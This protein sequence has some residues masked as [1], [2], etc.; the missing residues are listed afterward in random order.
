M[1]YKL[2]YPNFK[3]FYLSFYKYLIILLLQLFI[4]SGYDFTYAQTTNNSASITYTMANFITSVDASVTPNNIYLEYDVQVSGDAIVTQ[5]DVQMNY[6]TT[7]FTNTASKI[8]VTFPPSGPFSSGFNT[9]IPAVNNGVLDVTISGSSVQ[10]ITGAS[11]V[12]FFHVKILAISSSTTPITDAVSFNE[13]N[14]CEGPTGV[15]ISADPESITSGSS[16]DLAVNITGGTSP[17]SVVYSNGTDQSTYNNFTNGDKISV[18]PTATTTYSIISVTDA[19]GITLN[20]GTSTNLGS[21]N[22]TVTPACDGPTTAT[23]SGGGTFCSNDPNDGVDLTV[24]VSGGSGQP[25]CSVKLKND[26]NT[27]TLEEGETSVIISEAPSET[28]TYTIESVTYGTCSISSLPGSAKV[29]P[30]TCS[31]FDCSS[32]PY[33]CNSTNT[34]CLTCEGAGFTCDE[35]YGCDYCGDCIEDAVE[36]TTPM[37]YTYTNP[38][39][40]VFCPTPNMQSVTAL[41]GGDLIA[42]QGQIISIKGSGFG[43]GRGALSSV[44]FTNA[45]GKGM[46]TG[47]GSPNWYADQDACDYQ[48]N[49]GTNSPE[50]WTD[51]EIKMFLPSMLLSPVFSIGSGPMYV[52]TAWNA[53]SNTDDITINQSYWTLPS[54]NVK[55]IFYLGNSSEYPNST[56]TFLNGIKFILGPNIL[57][58]QGAT[59]CVIAALESWACQLNTPIIID[60]KSA[61]NTNYDNFI[62]IGS[63]SSNFMGTQFK[64]TYALD[65]T[66][67]PQLYFTK[68]FTITIN[69]NISNLSATSSGWDYTL[70]GQ[71]FLTPDYGNFYSAILHEIGHSLLL[72][73]LNNQSYLMYW[74]EPSLIAG[75]RRK[76]LDNLAY[77]VNCPGDISNAQA[78]V[79][80]SEALTNPYLNSALLTTSTIP[81]CPILPLI[82]SFTGGQNNSQNPTQVQLTWS[83]PDPNAI[84]TITRNDGTN[85]PII[86]T[87]PGT[88]DD[89]NTNPGTNYVYT[90]TASDGGIV[91]SQ[92]TSVTTNIAV[93]Q[94]SGDV[95]LT[96]PSNPSATNYIVTRSTSSG[97]TY[98]TIVTTTSASYS[99]NTVTPGVTYY[100]KIGTNVGG[101]ITYGT[102]YS[103]TA[104][105][106]S[107]LTN[108]TITGNYLS[109]PFIDGTNLTSSGNVDIEST[110]NIDLV[111]TNS[112]K[113]SAGFSTSKNIQLYAFVTSAP[114]CPS[115]KSGQSDIV[116]LK[117]T[118][119]FLQP[120][121]IEGSKINIYPNPT[122]GSFT[123]ENTST[124]VYKILVFDIKGKLLME[125]VNCQYKM[126]LDI[127]NYSSGIYIIRING[128]K[129]SFIGKLLKN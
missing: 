73:H 31:T 83:C 47:T 89:Y 64:S 55:P 72:S 119:T 49:A 38:E 44:Y 15:T 124:E 128:T 102:V 48:I 77:D 99:D 123:V 115:T 95:T 60:Y 67:N 79:S 80:E 17:Y 39:N 5:E 46:E 37:C 127:S 87:N 106:P 62:E 22:I 94:S 120:E 51:T 86:T 30:T 66:K 121:N 125:V 43:N 14:N 113:L 122:N 56:P 3:K 91:I 18:D 54:N 58:N 103:V 116:P 28:T 129:N 6:N 107:N 78:I 7:Y 117:D 98:S 23:L 100:Y 65:V 9:P 32:C 93:S 59:N 97:G 112:I 74:G 118:L 85:I 16:A 19:N 84:F 27:Y 8:F 114:V 24:T 13:D 36:I 81:S 2:N 69:G 96:I 61:T 110:A 104:C 34:N 111:A 40:A 53:C 52:N 105:M 45:D 88:A 4:V 75:D 71:P 20:A 92:V 10:L 109:T 57:S 12:T 11:P 26:D 29:T 1:I 35:C 21:V 25:Q 90:I 76:S 68:G 108:A 70:P 50:Y 82:N 41:N 101:T 126:N 33:G 63:T 42:G